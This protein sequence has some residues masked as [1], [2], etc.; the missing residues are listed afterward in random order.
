MAG[1]RKKS[2]ELPP[3]RPAPALLAGGRVLTTDGSVTGSIL[4]FAGVVVRRAGT[5]LLGPVDWEVCR[6]DR[7]TVVGPNGSGKTT[8]LQVAAGYLPRTAGRVEVLGERLG[9]VDAR[10][11]RRRIGLASPALAGAIPDR[12]VPLDVVVAGADGSLVPWW[13]RPDADARDRAAALLGQLGVPVVYRRAIGT[14]STGERQRVAIARALMS[15]P[16]LLL[17]DEPAAGLDL[18]AREELLDRLTA[19]ARADRPAAIV[20]VTHHVEEI[21]AGFDRALVLSGGRR[22]AGGPIE[23]ALTAGSLSAAYGLPL[24]VDGRDGRRFARRAGAG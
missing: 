21:P 19:L 16:E 3:R 24:V 11:L 20:L 12:L 4:R 14:L 5:T 17:L 8:L 2:F 22:V 6:G 18:G 10:A 23:E 9:G 15:D 7:W 1:A 13:S